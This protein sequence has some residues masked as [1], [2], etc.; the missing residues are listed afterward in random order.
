M[1]QDGGKYL[2]NFV[3]ILHGINLLERFGSPIRRESLKR[4]LEW[5]SAHTYLYEPQPC[6]VCFQPRVSCASSSLLLGWL[7][8]V[9]AWLAV[10]SMLHI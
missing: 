7:Y 4:L 3:Y 10:G 2:P 9:L 8:I 6:A 5:V 1:T